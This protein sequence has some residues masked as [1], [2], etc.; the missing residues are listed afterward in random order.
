MSEVRWLIEFGERLTWLMNYTWT[1]QEELAEAIGVT[2]ATISRY[3]RGLQ[4]PDIDNVI[5]IARE[6]NYSIDRLIDFGEDIH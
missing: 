2:Q 6:L 4:M 1:S 5:A 3:M